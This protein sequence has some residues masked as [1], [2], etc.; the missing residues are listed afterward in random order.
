MEGEK[1]QSSGFFWESVTR[2]DCGDDCE[3]AVCIGAIN[4]FI[5]IDPRLSGNGYVSCILA[6]IEGLWWLQ[7][8][9]IRI[10]EAP[11]STNAPVV[12]A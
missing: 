9:Q 6:C 1:C 8:L 10:G 11:D 5:G 3:A 7:L 12:G 4:E 2:I